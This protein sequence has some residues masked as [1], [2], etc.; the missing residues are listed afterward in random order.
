MKGSTLRLVMLAAC[1]CPLV[2]MAEEIPQPK[3]GLWET[4][5]KLT[6]NK[7][8][9]PKIQVVRVC[10]DARTAAREKVD[11]DEYVKNNCKKNT[12]KRIGAEW[13]TDRV[14]SLGSSVVTGHM[15]MRFSGENAYRVQTDSKYAPALA[16]T[17]WT[18]M[19][20]DAKRLGTC[21]P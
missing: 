1:L 10:V 20:V 16:G 14:C 4:R 2:V 17:T 19:E 15:V 7:K 6:S 13:V 8:S 21:K 3:T 11:A 12:T 5:I 9:A 18:R